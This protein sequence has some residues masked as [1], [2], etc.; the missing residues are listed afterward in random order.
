MEQVP[1]S[2]IM[3]FPVSTFVLIVSTIILSAVGS[4]SFYLKK[5]RL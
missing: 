3:N 5:W 4:I 2:V 1:N